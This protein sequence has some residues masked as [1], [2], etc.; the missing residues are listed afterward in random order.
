MAF[1][2]SP[3]ISAN[4][5]ALDERI[6]RKVQSIYCRFFVNIF[7][8]EERIKHAH[9]G[10]DERVCVRDKSV[11]I[12]NIE[13]AVRCKNTQLG[14]FVISFESDRLSRIGDLDVRQNCNC[15]F[16]VKHYACSVKSADFNIFKNDACVIFNANTPHVSHGISC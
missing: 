4:A 9:V 6:L 1:V 13:L 11:L 15:T 8:V 3:I 16:G 2:F 5:L 14:L 7:I 10:I 12:D